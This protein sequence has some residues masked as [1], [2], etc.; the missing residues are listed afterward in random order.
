MQGW[1]ET[2]RVVLGRHD[3]AKGEGSG[4]TLFVDKKGK[5]ERFTT[6]VEKGLFSNFGPPFTKPSFSL[7]SPSFF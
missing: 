6:K 1:S 4:K 5:V 3:E 2:E 7:T